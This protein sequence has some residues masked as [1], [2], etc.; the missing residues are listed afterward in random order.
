[1]PDVQTN[2]ITVVNATYLDREVQSYPDIGWTHGHLLSDI[3]LL[4]DLMY[5]MLIWTS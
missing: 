3:K 4:L 2:L 1:M 5:W